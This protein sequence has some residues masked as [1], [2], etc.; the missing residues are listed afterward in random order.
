VLADGDRWLFVANRGTGTISRIETQALRAV[1]EVAVGRGLADLSITPDGRYL[2]AADEAAGECIL[3]TRT[4]ADL[5]VFRR[6]P[7]GSTPVSV[8][9]LERGDR[10][11]V[12]GL[13]PRQ[14]TLLD[15][16][17]K[18]Q[19]G[20]PTEKP[21]VLRTIP[22][23]FAPR[24]Q[25]ALPRSSRV[26]VA[27][28]F[29]G[30]LAVVDV[31]AGRVESVRSVPGHN[32]RG[33]AL[34][35]DGNRLLLAHQVLHD[36]GRSNQDD[37][38]W[39]NLMT[40]NVRSLAL[41]R[42]LAPQ[43]DLLADSDLRYLGE[44]NQ[45]TGDPAGLAV[46][47]GGAVVV[48][49]GGTAEVLFGD[50]H[51]PEWRRVAV[52]RRP[53]AVGITADGRRAFVADTFGDA[54]SVVDLRAG[55]VRA[56]IPLGRRPKP[57]LAERGEELFY[58]ARLSHDGWLSCHSCHTDGHT[59]GRLNDNLTDGSFGTPKRVLSLLG[60]KDT[61]PWAWNGTMPSL[62]AQIRQSVRSTM[63]GQSPSEQQVRALAAYLRTLPPPP[64]LD[65]ARGT[66]DRAAVRR[67]REVFAKQGCAVC[68]A[69]PTYTTPKAYNVGL[70][71]EAG[72]SLFN[73]PSLRGVSQ[74]GPFFHDN[75]ARTLE[76]VFTR[77]RHQLKGELSKAEVSD[78][79]S[80]LRSL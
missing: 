7:V 44:V 45:G 46:T 69:A 50:E 18:N 10:C 55:K 2:V 52:G 38:H 16:G 34:S 56:E 24:K 65:P 31:E 78:L 39:G 4:G 73:P 12:A 68:H 48:S 57:T 67:G 47:A 43:A 70:K 49:V 77:Y 66:L 32:I 61:G 28:S 74:G 33:L 19:D 64:A 80:F 42:V 20:K 26:I 35:R 5:K 13:W 9:V 59:N 23:P 21:R 1:G 17:L 41:A 14:L 63:Q 72:K 29:G 25:L 40:G 22:L 58:D 79:L 3:L 54:V 76:E 51:R 62:E 36:L 15:L 11:A 71:D 30:R 27:D 8:C 60:A 75:R 37:I 6:V 53:T